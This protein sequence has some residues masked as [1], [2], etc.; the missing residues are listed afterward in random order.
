MDGSR[1]THPD[2]FVTGSFSVHGV[3]DVLDY[4]VFGGKEVC[5]PQ[6]VNATVV[7]SKRRKKKHVG[8]AP[9]PRSNATSLRCEFSRFVSSAVC[10][11][12]AFKILQFGI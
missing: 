5:V 11:V 1:V 7:D 2:L 8:F 10:S 4:S 3:M 6:G 12:L 9:S